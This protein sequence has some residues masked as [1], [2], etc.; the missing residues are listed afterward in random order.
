MAR[1]VQSNLKKRRKPFLKEWRQFRN[2]NQDQLAER[3][4]MTQGQ[5]SN[6]ETGK[7]D[8]SGEVLAALADALL[9]EPQD[10]IMR[11]PL[12][13]DALWSITDQLR[14]APPAIRAQAAAIIEAL[15]K[16]GT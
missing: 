11:N 2:L 1:P 6:L 16:T 14:K 12:N 15:L 7:S 9:C 4:G 5:I 8:Y 3:V 10:L 13:P